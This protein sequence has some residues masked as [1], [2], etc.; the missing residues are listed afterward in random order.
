V[1]HTIDCLSF[2]AFAKN[3]LV[4]FAKIRIRE[5]SLVINDVTLHVKGE[6]RWA[7][8]PAKQQIKDGAV[9]TDPKTGKSAWAMILEFE[10]REARDD[11]S[12][13]V[14]RAV[15]AAEPGAVS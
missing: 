6:S 10:T 14:C 13:A 1:K 2:R 11:F 8:L 12:A 7:G 4:G 9:V 3:T 5:L 15:E